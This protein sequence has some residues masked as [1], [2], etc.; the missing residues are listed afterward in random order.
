[1]KNMPIMGNLVGDPEL[2][3]SN[4]GRPMCNMR[5]GYGSKNNP[6]YIDLLALDQLAIN[7]TE[8]LGK[9]DSIVGEGSLIMQE[10]EDK[11]GNKR[12][13]IKI[14]VHRLGPDLIRHQVK[15]SRTGSPEE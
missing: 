1:M 6:L 2:R 5:L 11:N 10:W 4:K 7:C 15:I 14:L 8:C 13:S 3:M 9:G 12:D